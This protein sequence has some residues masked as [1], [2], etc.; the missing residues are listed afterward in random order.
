MKTRSNV[1]I[2]VFLFLVYRSFGN[3]QLPLQEMTFRNRVILVK[4]KI[5]EAE[6]DMETVSRR[7]QQTTCEKLKHKMKNDFERKAFD[8]SGRSPVHSA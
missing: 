6:R 5:Q 2:A 4:Y 8:D 7:K 1:L 3:I